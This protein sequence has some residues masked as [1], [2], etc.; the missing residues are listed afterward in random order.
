MP[1]YK[2]RNTH[3]DVV[4]AVKANNK[5]QAMNFMMA[6]MFEAE[7]MTAEEVVEYMETGLDVKDATPD[8]GDAGHV[9]AKVTRSADVQAMDE[10]P[11]QSDDYADVQED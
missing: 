9:E 5:A 8:Q 4:V 7:P 10:K 2:I 3:S 11:L 1:I 6:G